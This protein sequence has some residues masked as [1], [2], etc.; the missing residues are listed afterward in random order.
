MEETI[1]EKYKITYKLSLEIRDQLEH[2]ETGPDASVFLQGKISTNI[3]NL[4]RQTEQL[5]AMVSQQSASR[6]ELWRIR[7]KQ[8]VDECK[9]LRL[10]VGTYFEQKNKQ[11]KQ[12]ELRS[13][14]FERKNK[15]VTTSTNA[16]SLIKEGDSIKSS[17]SMIE[18]IEGVGSTVRDAIFN[19]NDQIRNMQ[20]K[21]RDIVSSLGLSN[22]LM[23]VIQRRQLGDKIITYT[24]MVLT[25]VLIFFLYYYV[26]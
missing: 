19:Q 2:L 6:R 15:Q 13:Q 8:L 14:L 1:D 11:T 9:S 7:I 5:E 20:S 26:R 22:S 4:S 25:L 18:D 17:I 3:N 21:V 10:S 24:G 12:E 16:Q 23:K